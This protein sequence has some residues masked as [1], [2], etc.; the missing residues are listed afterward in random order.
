MK[1]EFVIGS[2]YFFST[3]PDYIIKDEDRLIVEDDPIFYKNHMNIKGQGKDYFY[4][5]NKSK[6]EW[7][8]ECLNTKL[9]MVIGKFLIPEFAEFINLTIDDLSRLQP[10]VDRLDAKHLYEKSIYDFYIEN[11]SFVLTREALDSAYDIYKKYRNY[12]FKN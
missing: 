9:P 5:K 4:F 8:E 2:N 1:K 12:E 7:I 3:Y 11:N 6:E 10:V